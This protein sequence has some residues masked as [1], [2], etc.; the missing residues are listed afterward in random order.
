MKVLAVCGSPRKGNTEWIL[1]KLLDEVS[2]AGV[3]TE[4][5]L[6][7][8]MNIGACDGCLACEAGG[9]QRKNICNIED[10]MQGLYPKLLEADCLI[11][12]TPVYFEMLSGQLKTFI[13]RTCPIWTKLKNKRIVGIAVAEEGIGK[14]M[15]NLRTYAAVCGMDWVGSV[16]ALAKTPKEASKRPEIAGRLKI[17]SRKIVR[18]VK[19]RS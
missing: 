13:D 8:E 12:G 1:R 14:A 17:L 19:E 6:L 5:L 2:Q 4:L 3:D 9:K 18:V 7:R 16:T 11:F 10:D 15:Q